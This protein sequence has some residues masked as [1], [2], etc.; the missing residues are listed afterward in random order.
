M[1][2]CRWSWLT[3]AVTLLA[4][5]SFGSAGSE[6]ANNDKT[7][8]VDLVQPHHAAVIHSLS[9]HITAPASYRISSYATAE[10]QQILPVGTSVKKGQ[11]VAR[12]DDAFMQ[13]QLNILQTDLETA[14]VANRFAKDEFERMARLSK[15]GLTAATDLNNLK[16]QLDS[17]ELRI[18]RLQQEL[19]L[20]TLKKNKLNHLAPFDAQV[21]AV[22]AEP[23]AQLT[24]GQP[25]MQL[26]SVQ[27]KQLECQLPLAMFSDSAELKKHRYLLQ[28]QALSLREVSQTLDPKTESLTLYFDHPAKDR[29]DLLVGQTQ[30]I[31]MQVQSERITRVPN[32]AIE[33]EGEEFRSWRISRDGK[34]EKV[35]LKILSTNDSYYVVDS[36]LRPGEQVVIRGQHG[37]KMGQQVQADSNKAG[38]SAISYE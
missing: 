25:I 38:S 18:Q 24:E 33:L 26:L 17:S 36:A 16:F 15:S 29:R 4:L 12:Q 37:L 11:L 30:F 1:P 35:L 34:A 31:E 9:C 22:I 2:E 5:L 27:N 14:R 28:N 3:P 7:V 32:Q 21:M 6:K 19:A 20:L 10:L 13:R 8:L 23:G